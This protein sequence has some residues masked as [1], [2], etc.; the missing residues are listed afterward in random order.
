MNRRSERNVL[1]AVFALLPQ[2]IRVVSR[3][4]RLIDHAVSVRSSAYL[5]RKRCIAAL[6]QTVVNLCRNLQN[7]SALIVCQNANLRRIKIHLILLIRRYLICFALPGRT[8]WQILWRKHAVSV[9]VIAHQGVSALVRRHF[10]VRQNSGNLNACSVLD[11]IPLMELHIICNRRTVIGGFRRAN[12]ISVNPEPAALLPCSAAGN[13]VFLFQLLFAR[14]YH[15]VISV[16]IFYVQLYL[17]QCRNFG[18][19]HHRFIQR[20]RHGK[21]ITVFDKGVRIPR[22]FRHFHVFDSKRNQIDLGRTADDGGN[23][24]CRLLPVFVCGKPIIRQIADMIPKRRIIVF[25]HVHL[26]EPIEKSALLC[27][28]GHVR[29]RIGNLIFKNHDGLSVCF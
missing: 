6:Q 8:L 10:A 16:H 17:W 4:G 3:C 15:N 7:A 23:L 5:Y 28:L 27:N 29:I 2:R 26:T 1:G 22:F 18:A 9:L 25:R 13:V 24:A 14:R 20:Q 21:H 19:A 12:P 11:P